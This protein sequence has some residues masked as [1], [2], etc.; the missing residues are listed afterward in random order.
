LC[1][2]V[3]GLPNFAFAGVG[4]FFAD[5]GASV[6]GEAIEVAGRA[7][8]YAGIFPFGFEPVSFSR[9]MRMG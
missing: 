3:S 2:G 8:Y 7:A 4:E 5:P 1:P 6:G 9:R